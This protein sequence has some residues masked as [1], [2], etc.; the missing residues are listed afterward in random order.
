MANTKKETPVDD[1]QE[2]TTVQDTVQEP[3]QDTVPQ[4]TEKQEPANKAK[5]YSFVSSNK[6]LTVSSLGVQFVNGKATV[7][8]L[9]VARALATIEGVTLI[10]D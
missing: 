1:V 3:A 9:T 7:T 8:D 10:E 5:V 4:D 6:Y 2:T